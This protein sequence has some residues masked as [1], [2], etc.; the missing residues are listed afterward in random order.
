MTGKAGKFV[1]VMASALSNCSLYSA[2]H[3][4]VQELS[5]KALSLLEELVAETG[6]LEMMV[7]ENALVMNKTPLRDPGIHEANLVRRLRRKGISRI[8][9]LKGMPFPELMQLVA[10]L[11]E[12]DRQVRPLPHIKTGVIDVRLSAVTA[13]GDMDAEG[14]SLLVSLQRERAKKVYQGISASGRLN[15]AGIEEIV[16]AFIDAFRKKADILKMMSPVTSFRE[17]AYAH[18]MNVAALSMFQAETLG[19]RDE[20]LYDIGIAALLH[21]VGKLF[22]PEEIREKEGALEDREWEELRRHTVYG[23]RYLAKTE[24][25]SRIAP[26]VALEHHL[27]YD[28]QG[29]PRLGEKERKQHLFT[30]IVAVADF[31][32]SMRSRRRDKDRIGT[33]EIITL[34]N[35]KAGKDL[36]PF[37]V[38]HFSEAINP[39]GEPQAS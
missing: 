8:D 24:G 38:S 27:G 17:Q 19:A 6:V 10:D 29:Y 26:L 31:F 4:A 3:E 32:D 23:A 16:V 36:N 7:V 20:L 2:E 28:G 15:E 14:L 35:R 39:P 1:T 18:A 22:I 13:E 11:A 25:L 5:R 30:Q 12:A 34:M 37:L 33:A 21:D 9:F